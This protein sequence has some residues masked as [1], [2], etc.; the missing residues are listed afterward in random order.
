LTQSL[1]QHQPENGEQNHQILI[2]I[3]EDIHVNIYVDISYRI[4][5]HQYSSIF[6]IQRISMFF[7]QIWSNLVNMRCA[8]GY[9]PLL[10]AVYE[11]GPVGVSVAA[12]TW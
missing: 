3:I 11:R 8:E 6:N 2:K 4:N 9:E 5:I 7:F 10:R 1:K 12:R